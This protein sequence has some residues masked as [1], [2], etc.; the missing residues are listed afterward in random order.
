MAPSPEEIEQKRFLVALRGYDKHEV[1]TY[2]REIAVAHAEE[3]AA[4]HRDHNEPV[5]GD[6]A[7]PFEALGDKVASIARAAAEAAQAM[8]TDS[9]RDADG[10]RAAATEEAGAGSPAGSPSPPGASSKA[11]DSWGRRNHTPRTMAANTSAHPAVT[12]RIPKRSSSTPWK[13]APSG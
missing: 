2:L 5:G 10:R 13:M 11:D 6:L 12:T 7:D 4:A 9:E 1:D 8:L 3:L